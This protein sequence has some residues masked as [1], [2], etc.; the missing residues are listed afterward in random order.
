MLFRYL[1][2]SLIL[3]PSFATATAP[4][5]QIQ[6]VTYEL[7]PFIK[8][9]LPDGGPAISALRKLF[10]KQGYELKV[11]F[12]PVVRAKKQAVERPEVVAFFP[13]ESENVPKDFIL[14]RTLHKSPWVMA[15]SKE[16][17]V[18]WKNYS[19]LTKYKIGNVVGYELAGVLKPLQEKKLL[20]IEETNSDEQNLMKVAKNR[21]DLAFIDTTVFRK[22]MQTSDKLEPYKDKLQLNPRP[23][24]VYQYAIAFRNNPEGKEVLR[25]FN[26]SF[27]E[28]EFLASVESYLKKHKA[29]LP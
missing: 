8:E 5:K 27:S 28:S 1:V 25:S 21:I 13:S 12:A 3:T 6:V 9:D 29:L 16:H 10:L 11:S 20:N 4:I 15:E 26:A 19:D 23:L 24:Q 7:S 22:L 2:A 18:S 14:S 17:P